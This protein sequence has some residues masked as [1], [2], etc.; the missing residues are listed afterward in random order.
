LP[1]RGHANFNFRYRHSF[2]KSAEADTPVSA[3]LIQWAD[4]IIDDGSRTSEQAQPAFSGLLRTKRIIVLGI[5][6]VYG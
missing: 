5:P 6:D 2:F 4:M 1:R 3:D